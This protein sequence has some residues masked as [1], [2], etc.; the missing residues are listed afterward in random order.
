MRRKHC[1]EFEDSLPTAKECAWV[2]VSQDR[3]DHEKGLC[4]KIFTWCLSFTNSLLYPIF[5]SWFD[6]LE[7]FILIINK[8]A[9][10]ELEKRILVLNV[11]EQPIHNYMQFMNSV[12]CYRTACPID[13]CQL[14]N[15]H[16]P[17]L[18]RVA[19]LSNGLYVKAPSSKSLFGLLSYYFLADA[20]VRK[21]IIVPTENIEPMKVTCSC[22]GKPIQNDIAYVCTVCLSILCSYHEHCPIHEFNSS[23]WENQT[24]KQRNE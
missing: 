5:V 4:S 18:K 7:S 3:W 6:S 13:I 20:E 12:F 9:D 15:K 17:F 11:T 22:H 24:S 10:P 19:K 8:H 21:N 16:S 23:V 2:F 14:Y 1:V